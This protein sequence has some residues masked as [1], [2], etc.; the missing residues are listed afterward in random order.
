VLVGSYGTGRN[1]FRVQFLT[2]R[3]FHGAFAHTAPVTVLLDGGGCETF[4]L[5]RY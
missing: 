2:R 5:M 3:G 4:R 1:R